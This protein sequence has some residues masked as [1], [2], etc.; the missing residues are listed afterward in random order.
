MIS[1][2]QK[3]DCRVFVGKKYFYFIRNRL[4]QQNHISYLP[5]FS[6]TTKPIPECI[7]RNIDESRTLA[8]LR[9]GLLPKL[10]SGEIRG[11]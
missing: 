6:K 2:A 5:P 10:L 3:S 7:N 4:F 8:A 11:R 1:Q 9:D